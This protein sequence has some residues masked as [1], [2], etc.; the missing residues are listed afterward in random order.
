MSISI[1]MKLI[2]LALV[3]G[4]AAGYAGGGRLSQLSELRVRYAP[5]A[6]LGLLLQLVNPPGRWPLAM[7]IASFVL[8][9]VFILGNLRITG[10]ALL[11]IGVSMNFAV[12]AVNG[13]MP[14]SRSAVVASGQTDTL[15]ALTQQRGVKHHLASPDDRVLFL[16][17][18]IAIPP[19]IGLVISIGDVFTYAGVGVVIAAAMRRRERSS[20]LGSVQGAH[21]VQL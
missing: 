18:V 3:L 10:F 5:L 14:V 8:L 21:G 1:E 15:V 12:I 6:L 11:L 19:P 7:L 13:G 2:A 9:V 17:D 4:I 16:G 20:V